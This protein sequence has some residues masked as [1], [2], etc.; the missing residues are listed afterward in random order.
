[1]LPAESR[2]IGV[3]FQEPRLFPFLS[4]LENVAFPLAARGV[5][6]AERE[7]RARE[8]LELASASGLAGRGVAN[9]SGG[10]AQRVALARAVVHR[11]PVGLLDERL[12]SLDARLRRVLREDL[13][14]LLDRVGATA[15]LVTHDQDD[16]FALGDE[17]AI[18]REGRLV[19]TGSPESLY[20]E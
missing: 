20:R 19:E 7:A 12:A 13:A 3:A 8:A 9:L 2:P 16:A 17:L 1:R 11:P 6:R 5:G 4:V 10:E 14:L 18:L 15:L